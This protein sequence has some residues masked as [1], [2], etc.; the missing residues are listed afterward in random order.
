[1]TMKI[2]D[3]VSQLKK[4]DICARRRNEKKSHFLTDAEAVALL[5]LLK[6]SDI[7]IFMVIRRDR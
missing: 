3:E 7:F 5:P 1:M 6:L 2:V 4:I